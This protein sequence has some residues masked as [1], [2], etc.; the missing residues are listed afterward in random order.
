MRKAGL[1]LMLLALSCARPVRVESEPDGAM[2]FLDGQYR[3][4]TP[5]EV[6][7]GKK[8]PLLKLTKRGY[9]PRS[10]RVPPGTVSVKAK[11]VPAGKALIEVT[12]K[13]AGATV[14]LD[15]REAGVTPLSIA[16]EPG[17]HTLR[18][19]RTDYEPQERTLAVRAGDA[20]KA[21]FDL[22]LTY[23]K[24]SLE[25]I[26]LE[27]HVLT[28]YTDLAHAYAIHG[29]HDDAIRTLIEGL[30]ASSHPKASLDDISRL[31]S[32][33]ERLYSEQFDYGDAATVQSVRQ[34]LL[35]ALEAELA[36]NPKHT[37]LYRILGDFY[38]K[39]KAIQLYQTAIAKVD[40]PLAKKYFNW[41]LAKIHFNDAI[42]LYRQ[43]KW[44]EAATALQSI[45]Q[46]YPD[47]PTAAQAYNHLRPCLDQL[48][49]SAEVPALF[50]Q[51]GNR[52]PPT[53]LAVQN[54]AQALQGYQAN[55][56]FASASRVAQKLRAIYKPITDS[57][58]VAYQLA[59]FYT[60]T[61]KAAAIAYLESLIP[62]CT[63]ADAKGSLLSQL[64]SLYTEQKN[65]AKLDQVKA[66]LLRDC[67]RTGYANSYDTKLAERYARGSEQLA[68]AAKLVHAKEYAKA[69]AAYEKIVNEYKD[70]SCGYSALSQIISIYQSYLRDQ[71]KAAQE[72]IR[73]AE[74]F[75]EISSSPY[76]LYTAAS[77]IQTRDP[78]KAQ[79]LYTKVEQKYPGTYYA[80]YS[81]H[82]AGYGLYRARKYNEAVALWRRAVDTY[83]ESDH[84]AWSLY[85]MSWAYRELGDFAAAQ[86]ALEEIVQRYPFDSAAD[87]AL[88]VIIQRGN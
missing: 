74:L 33:I 43:Q 86:K 5:A 37:T 20:A 48:K 83:P 13:P 1:L 62:D 3:G 16:T 35:A 44:Q 49:R 78:G 25:K 81:L 61:D 58:S 17:E 77:I 10:L 30:R 46:N 42:Q 75:P 54:L 36:A 21:V 64:A 47:S 82:M 14:L 6:R 53:G 87:T 68:E 45:I 63:L 41:Q 9:E 38:E 71:D 69:V 34:K 66:L 51:F 84:N 12:T 26:K 15:G 23:E 24:F 27:P 76:Y 57:Y 18:V 8:P 32:E 85:Y 4:S 59:A 65:E 56:D 40:D 55:K 28:H 70:V 88:G 39:P 60:T 50:E 2:I 52:C 7:I 80:R 73:F 72:M 29:R 67:R 19:T 31:H 22:Q 11:L 79:E